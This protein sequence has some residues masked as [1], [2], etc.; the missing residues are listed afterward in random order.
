LGTDRL[1]VATQRDSWRLERDWKE[2]KKDRTSVHVSDGI[3]TWLP[4]YSGAFHAHRAH[5]DSF[6]A[7][8]LLDPSWLA[9]YDWD[10][11][12]PN[13]RN[14]RNVLV[15]H[16]RV[17]AAR[18]PGPT[19]NP[20]ARTMSRLRPP[21]EVEVAIDAEYGFLHRIT[22]LIDGQ[23]PMVEELVDLVVDPPLDES[24]FRIDPSKFEVID[25]E[26]EQV[27]NRAF[28]IATEHDANC[29][30]I[31]MLAALSEM[32]GP[33]GESLR[34]GGGPLL[35]RPPGVPEAR[36]GGASYLCMQAQEATD[37]FASGRDEDRSPAHLLLALIDQGD[38]EA[39]G[40]LGRSGI[41][42]DTVRRVAL[43]ELGL[44]TDL[45]AINVP[46][47]VPAGYMDRPILTEP[48]LDPH[49]WQ[50]LL[51]RQAH[52]PLDS[53]KTSRDWRC[54]CDLEADT[55]SGLCCRLKL[56]PD[57][58]LS[59]A[60]HHLRRVQQIA[61]DAHPDLVPPVPPERRHDGPPVIAYLT[62]GRHRRHW[63][64]PFLSFTI[65]WGTWFGNRW[66]GIKAR[67]DWIQTRLF[68]I[69]ARAA[70]KGA[71]KPV[72]PPD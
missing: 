68:A 65:G 13:V 16:A 17:A 41:D 2:R 4:T 18:P 37:D 57:Q 36:G 14:G 30:P 29:R 46:P 42:R 21:A 6:P 38:A 33:I 40:F 49:A 45:P 32:E 51:W 31:H 10:T 58:E 3:T 23:P 27:L 60:Q 28:C 24:V 54:L 15:M 63:Q 20:A 44:P 39:M 12:L 71:P 1:W 69:R 19:D 72:H 70:Y 11:P 53:L 22:G 62:A 34:A 50:T 35:P 25:N 47:P 43:S 26:F 64:P 61:H 55:A 5:P 56:H 66:S 67:R 48:E 9:G 7:R 52:L 59:L 8:N